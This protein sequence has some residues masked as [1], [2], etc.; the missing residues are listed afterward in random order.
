MLDGH[1]PHSLRLEKLDREKHFLPRLLSAL[2]LEEEYCSVFRTSVMPFINKSTGC[3][4]PG[5]AVNA[6][7]SHQSQSQS[8]GMLRGEIVAINFEIFSDIVYTLYV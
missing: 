8:E 3:Y 6:S 5:E 4:T 1:K 2:T 7:D